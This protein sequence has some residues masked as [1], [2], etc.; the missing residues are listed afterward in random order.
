MKDGSHVLKIMADATSSG[1]SGHS[2]RSH[3][4]THH[5]TCGG[6]KPRISDNDSSWGLPSPSNEERLLGKAKKIFES[7]S[8]HVCGRK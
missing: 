8:G 6:A 5:R 3:K 4:K 1:G 2:E 7:F